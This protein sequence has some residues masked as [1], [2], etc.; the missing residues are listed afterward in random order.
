MFMTINA[1][2]SDKDS[3]N[4]TIPSATG[5]ESGIANFLVERKYGREMDDSDFNKN[6]TNIIYDVEVTATPLVTVKVVLDELTGDEIKGRG[7]G[8][9]KIGSG[10][11]EPLTLRGRFDIDEGEYLFTFQSFFKKPFVLKKG[12]NNYI[13]WS[14][15]P[16]EARINLTAV[17]TATNVSFAP[18]TSSLASIDQ[19]QS[20]S[21]ARGDVYV[22][23]RLTEK[24]FQPKFNLSL[25]FPQASVVNSDPALAFS[26]Q[27]LQKNENEMNKQATYLVVLGVFAP[28]EGGNSQNVIGEGL[29]NSI[30]GIFFNVIN[31]QV[32]KLISGI[33][34]L[35][36]WNFNFN[37][38]LYSRNPIEQGGGFGSNVNASLGRSFL[39]NR[40]IVTASGSVEGIFQ[41]GS[42]TT[43]QQ[44]AILPDITLEILINPSGTFRA[45]LFYRENT[46]YLT[47]TASSKSQK[48]TGVGLSYRKDIDHIRDLF[49]RKKN[50]QLPQPAAAEKPVGIKEGEPGKE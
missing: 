4:V 13:E 20:L 30:S 23:A 27:Q 45:V 40:V 38:S 48:K 3:S 18:L 6:A 5:R 10:T 26:L 22:I 50:R 33:F 14:G 37:S 41:T 17:Y 46:D 8:T 7:A 11:S 2:A 47:T 32:K 29:T 42:T 16:N 24:L 34:N 9:L 43:R 39:N 19:S 1:I 44:T 35:E 31:E 49:R 12:E 28:V 25:E 36:K 21:R 15:D